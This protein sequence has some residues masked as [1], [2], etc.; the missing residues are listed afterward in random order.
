MLKLKADFWT[1]Y[2]SSNDSAY[3]SGDYSQYIYWSVTI[4][5]LHKYLYHSL[6]IAMKKNYYHP[7]MSRCC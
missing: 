6:L 3:S 4:F 1:R 5:Q 2:N 7:G